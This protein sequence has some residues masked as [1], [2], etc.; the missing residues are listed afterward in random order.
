MPHLTRSERPLTELQETTIEVMRAHHARSG[1]WP[2]ASM[3]AKAFEVSRKTMRERLT[4]IA[5]HGAAQKI[6][7]GL[8]VP[9]DVAEESPNA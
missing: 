6:A 1:T 4:A 9:A 5:E 2:T 7:P 3:L 8:W